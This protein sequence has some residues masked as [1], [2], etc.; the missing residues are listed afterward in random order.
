MTEALELSEWGSAAVE[1]L[2]GI[3]VAVGALCDGGRRHWVSGDLSRVPVTA[4]TRFYAGSI[5]KQMVAALVARAEVDGRLDVREG[6]RTYLPSLPAWTAPIRVR[7]L[8]H[9]TAGLPQPRVLA[10]A[11]G[12]TD[13]AEGWSR[14]DDDAVLAG[15]HRVTPPAHRPGAAFTYDNTGYILLAQL[16]RAVYGRD[17]ADVIRPELFVPLG[18]TGSRLGGPA[19]VV[20]PGHVAPPRTTGDGGLWTN[21]ADLLTWLEAMNGEALGADVSALVCT[22]GELDDGTTLDYAWGIGIREGPHDTTVYQHGGEWPGWSA[23]TLRCPTAATGVAILAAT[24]NM[25]LVSAA[26]RELHDL[27]VRRRCVRA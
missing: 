14:L 15:L 21:L 7:H 8:L 2:A 13:D 16:V 6:I 3:P 24:E 25:P 10:L 5:T 26:A 22:P 9:H 20:L 4:S 11:L 17:L 12:S 1:R 27:L 18:M 19:P 23:M